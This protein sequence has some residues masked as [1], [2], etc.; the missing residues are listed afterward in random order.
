[1]G[2]WQKNRILTPTISVSLAIAVGMFAT[3]ETTKAQ[4]TNTPS[5][6]LYSGLD[7]KGPKVI[8]VDDIANLGSIQF[9]ETATSLV[10]NGPWEVCLG[11]DYS[12]RCRTYTGAIPNLESFQNRISSV[13][14]KGSEPRVPKVDPTPVAKPKQDELSPTTNKDIHALLRA[15]VPDSAIIAVIRSQESA[16][17]KSATAIIELVKSGASEAVLQAVI[18]A[19]QRQ[20]LG[21]KTPTQ[22]SEPNPQEARPEPSQAEQPVAQPT[23]PV[24]PVNQPPKVVGQQAPMVPDTPK[25]SGPANP[26]QNNQPPGVPKPPP[27]GVV[28]ADA[29]PDGAQEAKSAAE[30]TALSAASPPMKSPAASAQTPAVAPTAQAS[31][32]R[33]NAAIR[34][35]DYVTARTILSGVELAQ[36]ASA[37]LAL[38]QFYAGGIGGPKDVAAAE[39]ALRRA[40]ALGEPRAMFNV[41]AGLQKLGTPASLAEAKGWYIQAADKGV[42]QARE[43]LGV[44]QW[45]EGNHADAVENWRRAP[46]FPG[47]RMCLSMAYATG[48]GIAADMLMANYKIFGRS[49]SALKQG[50]GCVSAAAAAG[51]AEAQF[52]L[53]KWHLTKESGAFDPLKA[54][55]LLTAASEQQ[56]AQAAAY[57]ADILDEGTLVPRD[58]TGAYT[59]YLRAAEHDSTLYGRLGEMAL[60]GDGT[61]RSVAN[62]ISFWE[63]DNDRRHGYQ[64]GLIYA[65]GEG[66]PRDLNRAIP[67]M[68][69]AAGDDKPK[70]RAWLKALADSG[71]APG[72]LAYGEML[73]DDRAPETD[74]SGRE[75]SSDEVEAWEIKSRAQGLAYLRL[76]VQQKLP[77]AM[78][79]LVD[80]DDLSD[81]TK[82]RLWREAA[83]LGDASAMLELARGHMI[84]GWGLAKDKAAQRAWDERAARTGDRFALADLG[85]QYA[86][87]GGMT[88]RFVGRE[89]GAEAEMKELYLL[90]RRYY[91]AAFAAGYTG[92]AL[93]IASLY[94]EPNHPALDNPALAF[95]WLQ[96]ALKTDPTDYAMEQL[97]YH[98][99]KGRGTSVDP[100]KAWFWGRVAQ[101]S[102]TDADKKKRV[103]ALWEKLSPGLRTTGER[104]MMACEMKFYRGCTI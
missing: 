15:K 25:L 100:L 95:K 12:V 70:A 44:L 10:A 7:Y 83:A 102:S 88:K 76:A 58:A 2:N 48:K 74:A 46:E 65:G 94:N 13:R 82:V 16:V 55:K 62:A 93:D 54:I 101:G 96:E 42:Q 37:Q 77:A 8:I 24:S 36:S 30:T 78:V 40:A 67:A 27:S 103:D 49:L 41:A 6:V 53:G 35:K 33:A 87:S 47:S 84:G 75:L 85:R 39:A 28:T 72:Q 43:Q 69:S 11:I 99:E 5:L 34:A 97:S 92:A 68:L 104:A 50:T 79:A 90:A 32:D 29:R 91:E 63:K 60:K 4:G 56:H 61:E 57:L 71:N 1:M 52:L 89:A 80:R 81:G 66:W 26:A 73:I 22:A 21:S 19:N 31:I 64:L 45:S 18:S 3:L 9:D 23:Q 98:Y 86:I 14:Y 59:Y 20:N 51:S 38:Y 17:D